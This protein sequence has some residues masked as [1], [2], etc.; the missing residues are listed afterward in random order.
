M[1]RPKLFLHS[2]TVITVVLPLILS[3]FSEAQTEI[4]LYNFTGG[5]DGSQPQGLTRD[6]AGNLYGAT[7]STIFE[8]SPSPQG[9]WNFSTLYTFSDPVYGS[10][11]SPGFVFDSQGNLYGTTFAGGSSAKCVVSGGCGVIFELSPSTNGWA[12]TVLYNFNGEKDGF[13][14][15]GYLVFDAKGDLYGVAREGA[16]LSCNIQGAAVGCGTVFELLQTSG[17]W[18]LSVLHTFTGGADGA[19]PAGGLAIDSAG[20]LYDTTIFGGSR[21]GICNLYGCG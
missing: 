21:S 17:G 10:S 9:G 13:G 12:E 15:E 7:R 1:S 20:N 5:S 6:L 3:S 16:D 11:P 19:V 2:L 4:A 18:K 8:L 14:P